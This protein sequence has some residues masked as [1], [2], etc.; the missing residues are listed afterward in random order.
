MRKFYFVRSCLMWGFKSVKRP[1]T[2]FFTGKQDKKN[3]RNLAVCERNR[4]PPK[5]TAV[6]DI[7]QEGAIFLIWKLRH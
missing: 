6:H 5:Y 4:E 2:L 7:K 3:L 1:N